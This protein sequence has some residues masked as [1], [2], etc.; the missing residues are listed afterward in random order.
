MTTPRIPLQRLTQSIAAPE[1]IY[2][3]FRKE[4]PQ[5]RLPKKSA[6]YLKTVLALIEAK[7]G[8]R[9]QNLFEEARQYEIW[10]NSDHAKAQSALTTAQRI[11]NTKLKMIRK[12][13]SDAAKN[14]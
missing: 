3:Q 1:D 5:T 6:L 9:A 12:G 14:N 10:T 2:A 7:D 4:L 13:E 8:S 11:T